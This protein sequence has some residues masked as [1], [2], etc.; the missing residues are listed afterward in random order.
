MTATIPARRRE[1]LVTFSMI[2]QGG[3]RVAQLDQIISIYMDSPGGKGYALNCMGYTV[4]PGPKGIVLSDFVLKK[5]MFFTQAW[6]VLGIDRRMCSTTQMF[7][8][9]EVNSA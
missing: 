5:G 6:L 4:M 1:V 3:I 8:Q 9:M 2:L 7:R